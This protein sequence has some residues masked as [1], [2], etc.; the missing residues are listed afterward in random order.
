[1][2]NERGAP[3]FKLLRGTSTPLN[4]TK[5]APPSYAT[6]GHSPPPTGYLDYPR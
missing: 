3:E 5:S 1:M 6:D 4:L 2:R